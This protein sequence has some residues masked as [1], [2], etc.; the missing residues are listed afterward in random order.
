MWLTFDWDNRG[1]EDILVQKGL[2]QIAFDYP[3]YAI[4]YRVSSG[5]NGIHAF[6]ADISAE[7]D[8]SLSNNMPYLPLDLPDSEVLDYREY[9]VDLGLEDPVR[10]K[11]DKIR[12]LQGGRIGKIFFGKRGNKVGE[13]VLY[14]VE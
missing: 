9:M 8:N 7:P 12:I 13:W 11:W 1:L 14:G 10:L 3:T 6:V 2:K 5:G 4:Y